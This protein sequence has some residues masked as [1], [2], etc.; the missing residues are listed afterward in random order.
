[1]ILLWD[2]IKREVLCWIDI[3]GL[4]CVPC[5]AAPWWCPGPPGPSICRPRHCPPATPAPPGET[6]LGGCKQSTS[7][8]LH[9][10]SS[11]RRLSSY[12]DY[13][14]VF[15]LN[16]NEMSPHSIRLVKVAYKQQFYIMVSAW[17]V[18]WPMFMLEGVIILNHCLYVH[19]CIIRYK[20]TQYCWVGGERGLGSDGTMPLLN[21]LNS[22]YIY[23]QYTI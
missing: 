15:I 20:G 2:Y 8:W 11:L 6:G 18:V 7:P 22:N 1:M 5:R 9:C 13:Y 19:V 21:Q 14:D 3:V 10:W 4:T 17:L 23:S 16:S 12:P